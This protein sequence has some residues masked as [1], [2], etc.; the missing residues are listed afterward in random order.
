[1]KIISILK[2]VPDAEA[3]I[4]A[5]P[6]GIDLDNVTFVIGRDGRV[7]RRTGPAHS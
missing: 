1:M 3:R 7:R 6:E 4:R 5:T 2:Q